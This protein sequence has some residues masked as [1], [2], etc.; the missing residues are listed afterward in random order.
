MKTKISKPII[1]HLL[2]FETLSPEEI[3]YLLNQANKFATLSQSGGT[4]NSMHTDKVCMNLFYEPSTRTQYSF[5]IAAQKLGIN[6]INPNML[7]LS[8]KKGESLIDT[9]HAFEAMGVNLFIIRH[10]D[11]HTPHFISAELNSSCSIIN[12][13][14]GTNQHP[15]QT[16]IDLMTIQQS[17][18]RLSDLTVA[19][20]GDIS[21]SRVAHS[22]LAAADTLQLGQINLI[23]PA[24]FIPD[25]MNYNIPIS[26]HT[27]LDAGLE[28]ADVVMALRIQSERMDQN[29]L[30][31]M[32]SYTNQ[33]ALTQNRMLKAKDSAIILHPGPM[34]RG[35]EIDSITA[36]SEQSKILQQV[37]NSTY[38]RMAILDALLN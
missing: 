20:I 30:P 29:N 19:I 5:N 21:H 6:C 17:L 1:K 18:Q 34:V 8:D 23:G 33:Y 14:D 24:S 28:G 2:D 7:T 16:I 4:T 10:K 11:N 9:V 22:F 27:D 26:V 15:S 35:T 25:N 36:D 32:E 38:A 3:L 37:K 31:D 13:G 12:A